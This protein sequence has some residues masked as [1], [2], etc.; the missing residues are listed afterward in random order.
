MPASA[1]WIHVGRIWT[2]SEPFLAVE[3]AFRDAWEGF[4]NDEF[5]QVVELGPRR[6]PVKSLGFPLAGERFQFLASTLL[7]V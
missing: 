5:G 2:N 7:F 4:S 3:A 1:R 6:S